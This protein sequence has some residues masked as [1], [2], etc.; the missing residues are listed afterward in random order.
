MKEN[1]DSASDFE[2]ESEP[3]IPQAMELEEIEIDFPT[4]R[5][6]HGTSTINSLTIVQLRWLQKYLEQGKG[7]ESNPG[8][9][10]QPQ[11]VW[12]LRPIPLKPQRNPQERKKEE[13]E[14]LTT[15]R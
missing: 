7:K 13:D 6:I 4:L 11:E 12:V 14:N 8:Q 9:D 15:K 5:E 1:Q 2:E 3:D 10:I